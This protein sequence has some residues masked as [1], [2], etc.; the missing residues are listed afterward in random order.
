MRK[1][2]LSVREE[3]RSHVV[4][5]F[6]EDGNELGS[7]TLDPIADG[8]RVEVW[9]DE[10][11]MLESVDIVQSKVINPTRVDLT[12]PVQEIRKG[13]RYMGVWQA[14][15]DAEVADGLVIVQVAFTDGGRSSRAWD[16]V[17][18]NTIEITRTV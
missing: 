17:F 13:D 14:L 12:I 18:E 6:D 8:V 11:T 10:D 15:S 9:A 5:A 2:V 16:D 3:G 4:V 1:L 7:V